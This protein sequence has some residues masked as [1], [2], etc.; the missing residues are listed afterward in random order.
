MLNTLANHGFLPH[1]GRN[2]T[3]ENAVFA[4]KTALNFNATFAEQFFG[5][6]IKS[7]SDANATFFTL[8]VDAAQTSWSA[9]ADLF[10]RDMLNRH[11]VL[12]HDASLRSVKIIFSTHCPSLHC[13]VQA[14]ST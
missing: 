1:D 8:Y 4:L 11:N 9:I 2:I 12:E 6:G 5:H 14:S 10:P 13:A 7:N 3:K